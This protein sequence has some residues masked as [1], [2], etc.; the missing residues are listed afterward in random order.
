MVVPLPGD[1]GGCYWSA[2]W[3]RLWPRRL[4][5][6]PCSPPVVGPKPWPK[7]SS[8][9]LTLRGCSSL[10]GCF[11]P[12]PGLAGLLAA[13]L[14]R[15]PLMWHSRPAVSVE[16]TAPGSEPWPTE[17]GIWQLLTHHNNMT[18]FQGENSNPLIL[19]QW[20]GERGVNSCLPRCCWHFPRSAC[21]AD[22]AG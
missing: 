16:S 5:C 19:L 8:P 3:W 2:V 14:Q 20:P 9:T 10:G 6:W 13:R 15:G 7:K 17:D 11:L 21:Q 18:V 4:A 12:S 1:W 22:Q